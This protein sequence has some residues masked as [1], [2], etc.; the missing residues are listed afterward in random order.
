M[1]QICPGEIPQ[2]KWGRC[3]GEGC[4]FRPRC[5]SDPRKGEREGMAEGSLL[6]GRLVWQR[7]WEVL[8]PKSTIRGKWCLPPQAASVSPPFGYL[9]GRGSTKEGGPRSQRRDAFPGT[10][11]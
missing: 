5:T 9:A 6:L 8:E 7:C 4:S 1:C 2:E 11:H 10:R 3:W